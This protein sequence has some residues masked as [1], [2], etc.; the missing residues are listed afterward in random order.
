[1]VL[2]K[3]SD[4]DVV[5]LSTESFCA[6]NGGFTKISFLYSGITGKWKSEELE[7]ARAGQNWEVLSEGRPIT[8]MH[9]LMNNLMRKTIGIKEMQVK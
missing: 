6:H 9:F 3:R 5:K 1:V 2:E 4:R 8:K 7:F